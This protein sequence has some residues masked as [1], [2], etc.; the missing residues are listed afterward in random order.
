VKSSSSNSSS[1]AGLRPTPA[2]LFAVASAFAAGALLFA[3][4]GSE[5]PADDGLAD[6]GTTTTE[7]SAPKPVPTTPPKDAAPADTCTPSCATDDDCKRTCG[8]TSGSACC[9]VPTKKCFRYTGSA[10][11]VPPPPVDAST[12][13]GPY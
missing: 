7:A 6:S 5:T 2:A 13:P 9:D 8:A 4:A 10:C 12:P 11:P 1:A 3:C